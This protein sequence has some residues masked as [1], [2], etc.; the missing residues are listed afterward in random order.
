MRFTHWR[1]NAAALCLALLPAA[2][3]TAHHS[4]AEFDYSKQL[5]IEGKV[6]EVQWTNPHSWLQVLVPG[7]DGEVVEWG[8][9]LGAP[10]FN[11]RMGWTND[12]LVRGDEVIV[13]FC[14][15]KKARPRGT[16]MF[17]YREGEPTLNGVAANFFRGERLED[18]L[19]YPRPPAL[20]DD[21][22]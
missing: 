4:T 12:S 1:L 11:V 18:P 19:A 15:T 5:T 17:V 7:E 16:L 14:P 13:V 3:A 10:V 2:R 6:K 8:F 9:E 22:E 21:A 20:P